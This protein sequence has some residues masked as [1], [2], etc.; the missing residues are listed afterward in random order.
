MK[1]NNGLA[2]ELFTVGAHFG[3]SRTRR[4]PSVVPY[5]FG[6]KNKVDIIDV[7]K[8]ETMLVKATEFLAELGTKGKI[9]VFV[10]TK[11]EAKESTQAAADNINMPVVISRWVGGTLTNFSEIK[12]RIARLEELRTAKANGDLSKKYTKKEQLLITREMT[13]ME[14]LFSGL[15]QLKGLPDALVIVDPKKEVNAVREALQLDIPM[16]AIASTDCDIDE[17]TYPIL[18]NDASRA[19]IEFIIKK[20]SQA[21]DTGTASLN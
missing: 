19:S 16:I 12:K 15:T 7:E 9:V 4:H 11:P 6:T 8:T 13:K 1:E 3:Y 2:K 20:L 21:Y 14:E 18:A 17:V 5:L 10:G